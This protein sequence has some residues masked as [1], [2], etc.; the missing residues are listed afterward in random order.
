MV[1]CGERDVRRRFLYNGTGALRLCWRPRWRAALVAALAAL[2]AAGCSYRL[3]S[4]F[5][6][7]DPDV[8]PTG[9][10]SRQAQGQNKPNAPA[11]IAE[12]DLAYARATAA[13]ALARGGRDISIP[14][15][16]PHTGAGGNITPL[17]ASYSEGSATCRDFLASYVRGQA[18]SW[19]QGEACRS[20]HGQWEVR[21]L[22]PLKQG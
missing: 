12:V 14:W 2:S 11:P 20:E 16:N 1:A 4:I 19:L 3:D 15:Q 13:G 22:K 10:I 21:S 17:A 9:S 18:Q 5:P 8:E 6:K 7:S